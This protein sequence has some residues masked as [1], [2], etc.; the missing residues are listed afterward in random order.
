[1]A[2]GVSNGHATNDVTWPQ[3]CCEA[4]RSAILATACLLVLIVTNPRFYTIQF[5]SSFYVTGWKWLLYRMQSVVFAGRETTS[6][7]RCGGYFRCRS[8]EFICTHQRCDDIVDC[9]DMTDE[10]NCHRMRVFYLSSDTV[11]LKSFLQF[12]SKFSQGQ[13]KHEMEGPECW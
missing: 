2:Y 7:G 4:L 11:S 9:D 10:R 1:M 12:I 8:G 5:A 13:Q 6:V 3:R